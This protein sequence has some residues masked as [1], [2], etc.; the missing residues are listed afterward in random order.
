MCPFV[1]SLYQVVRC[2]TQVYVDLVSFD[3]QGFDLA[4]KEPEV[5][6]LDRVEDLEISRPDYRC[7]RLYFAQP[8]PYIV[9]CALVAAS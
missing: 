4:G 2:A 9:L 8:G 1:A 7:F 5:R 6:R 3:R